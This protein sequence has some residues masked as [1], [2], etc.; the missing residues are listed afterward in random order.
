MATTES[1]AV[2]RS[3]SDELVNRIV[4]ESPTVRLEVFE[5]HARGIVDW[6]FCQPS[7]ALFWFSRGV[8]RVRLSVDGRRIDASFSPSADLGLVP[9][10]SSLEG[11][12]ETDE[13]YRYAV[14]FLDE[15]RLDRP[16]GPGQCVFAF[17]N[18]TVQSSFAEVV[19]KAGRSDSRFTLLLEGW[20][21]QTLARLGP[22]LAG[23]GRPSALP[24]ASL[25]K[26]S[27]FVHANLN[28]TLTVRLLAEVAG[29]SERHF[30]RAFRDSTGQT[31]MEF[32][33]EVRIARAKE[34]LIQR[35]RPITEIALDCGFSQAQHFSVVFRRVTGT[36]PRRYSLHGE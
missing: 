24:A 2:R 5:R 11:E 14:A 22:A 33:T 17:G 27:D 16:L 31:P 10:L 7:P 1:A 3:L 34:L 9:A 23:T 36:T 18:P 25:R 30:A 29:Y 28:A 6:A 20:S 26:V 8:R 15:S 13:Y 21:L 12:I 19:R 4:E 32:V 35:R